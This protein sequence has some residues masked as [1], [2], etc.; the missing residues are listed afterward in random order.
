MSEPLISV[1]IPVY[2]VED[3]VVKCI[4]SVVNQ[5]LNDPIEIIVIDDCGEDNSINLAK[6]YASTIHHD[7]RELI[8]LKHTQNRGQAAARNTG[9]R[10]ARG[11]FLFFID[12]DDSIPTECLET[13]IDHTS[14]SEYDIIEGRSIHIDSTNKAASQIYNNQYNIV[15]EEELWQIGGTWSPVCWNKLI[16]RYF[17]IRHNL[18]FAEGFFYEDLYWAVLVALA[19][20]QILI[21]PNRT[22]YYSVRPGS[23]INS[24][25]E[26]HVNSFIM[27]TKHLAVLYQNNNISINFKSLFTANYERFRSIAIDYV[28][29]F[30]TN[31]MCKTMFNSLRELNL[32][33][34]S[35]IL[36]NKSIST[37]TKIKVLPLYIGQL[38]HYL[39]ILKSKISKL[40]R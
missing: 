30:C 22:Y 28:Y 12:S 37:K 33:S 29:A 18:F 23:T 5:T 1:I 40:F 32:C 16:N 4:S 19:N 24:M 15:K 6:E 7:N 3:Y 17:F 39:I 21:I 36:R 38:G 10:I 27:L 25:S 9:V 34:F 13:F 14:Q 11:K 26:R 31:E 20:P 2:N 8:F 35:Y